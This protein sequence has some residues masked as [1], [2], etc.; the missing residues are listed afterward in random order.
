MKKVISFITAA[1]FP[2]LALAQNTTV[3]TNINGVTQ[4]LIDFGNTV[5]YLLTSLAVVYIVWNVVQYFIKGN[6]ED[7]SRKK[8]G[9]NI[10]W[11]I[12]GLFVI[13]S[14]WG[15]VN[16]LVGTFQTAPSTQ[17][18]PNLSNDPSNGG[19]PVRQIPGVR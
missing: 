8:S 11:G 6:A 19:I 12:V 4:K 7:E 10:L 2:A 3:V 15:L 18:I 14:I 1:A 13:L 9:L 5:I 17:K 16:I